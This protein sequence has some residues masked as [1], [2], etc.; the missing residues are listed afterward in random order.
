M[1]EE[2]T[3]QE[4]VE[5]EQSAEV[6]ALEGQDTEDA[7]E[8]EQTVAE[9][10]LAEQEA[11]VAA[12]QEAATPNF[13]KVYAGDMVVVDGEDG[14]PELVTVRH[15]RGK[16][17]ITTTDGRRLGVDEWEHLPEQGEDE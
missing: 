14:E 15:P 3:E 13:P 8:P 12:I 5:L 7:A 10:L 11:R 1:A 17:R 4:Q 6:E 2:L 9:R 16:G